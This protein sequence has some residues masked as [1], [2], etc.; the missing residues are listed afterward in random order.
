MRVSGVR[1]ILLIILIFFGTVTGISQDTLDLSTL[2]AIHE[3]NLNSPNSLAI[4]HALGGLKDTFVKGAVPMVSKVPSVPDGFFMTP[5]P[6]D[7]TNG[8]FQLLARTEFQPSII[9]MKNPWVAHTK[10]PSRN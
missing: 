2:P 7:W 6:K 9:G 10:E 1:K 4:N 3:K 5:D 8:L